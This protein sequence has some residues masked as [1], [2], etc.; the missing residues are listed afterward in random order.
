MGFKHKAL[1]KSEILA[2]LK[3]PNYVLKIIPHVDGTP[4]ILELVRY[5]LQDITVKEAWTSPADLE[6]FH[7][8]L[9]DVAKLPVLE[10]LGSKHFVADIT[11]GLGEVAYDYL[12]D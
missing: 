7:H 8:A 11:I 9:A 12:A 5:Y 6:L 10:V 1:D 2:S 3:R 4:R